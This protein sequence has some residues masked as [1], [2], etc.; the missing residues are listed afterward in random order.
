MLPAFIV[1]A[2][3][4]GLLLLHMEARYGLDPLPPNEPVLV[5]VDLADGVD[6]TKLE[7]KAAQPG[8]LRVTAPP[9]YVADENR[10]FLRLAVTEPGEH[11]LELVLGDS[12]VEKR[13]SAAPGAVMAPTR[14]SGAAL[15]W[16]IGAEPPVD[17][18]T[19]ITAISL[20][21]PTS[22][23]TWLAMPWWG[24]WLLI[25]MVAALALRKTFNV[26]F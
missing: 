9:V 23:R 18:A 17:P 1:L 5:Q 7:A 24:F 12:Q 15:L 21:H 20:P 2:L 26:T 11:A 25:A 6:G 10:V 19:G 4:L 13:I 14:A 3:P 22:E 16:T 8:T